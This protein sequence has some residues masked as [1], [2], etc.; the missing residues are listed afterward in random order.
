MAD[1]EKE[2]GGDF[3]S[4]PF[5]DRRPRSPLKE[6]QV[7][8][9]SKISIILNNYDD[10]FSDFDPRHYSQRALSHDFL[11][12]IKRAAQDQTSGVVELRLLIPENQRKVSTEAVIKQ[13]LREH[14]RRHNALLGKELTKVRALGFLMVFVGAIL[15]IIATILYDIV[16]KGFL[17]KFILILMEPASWFSIWEGANHIFF[18]AKETKSEF[19][20]YKKMAKSE[21]TF[22]PY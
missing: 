22:Q 10:I 2:A 6:D 16:E 7:L 5:L 18:E 20:F 12:E 8:Q 1:K 14:F 13:R 4:T 15:G 3:Y 21:I 11:P 17:L 19:E 9:E